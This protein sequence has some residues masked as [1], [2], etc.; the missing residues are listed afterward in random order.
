MLRG[1]HL[2]YLPGWVRTRVPL[3]ILARK[4]GAEENSL[5]DGLSPFLI[6]FKSSSKT[7]SFYRH[8]ALLNFREM[9]SRSFC[10]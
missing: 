6:F 10:M 1:S 3:D 9:I 5:K 2:S 4:I 7:V 8:I